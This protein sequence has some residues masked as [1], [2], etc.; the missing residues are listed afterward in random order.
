MDNLIL[1]LGIVIVVYGIGF[2]SG[3]KARSSFENKGDNNGNL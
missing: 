2:V 1:E 3:F